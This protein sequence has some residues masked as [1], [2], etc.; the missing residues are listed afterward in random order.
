MMFVY[1]KKGL[2][3]LNN[4]N[5][6]IESLDSPTVELLDSNN[7]DSLDFTPPLIP[8]QN[9]KKYEPEKQKKK[10]VIGIIFTV[11]GFIL[12]AAFMAGAIYYL[13]VFP[14]NGN[15][16]LE[17][18]IDKSF[19]YI[20]YINDYS[21][22]Y[23]DSNY[24]NNSVSYV[25]SINYKSNNLSHDYIINYEYDL[26]YEN[27]NI[28]FGGALFT[29][30]TETNSFI[31]NYDNN[32]NYIFDKN[33]GPNPILLSNKEFII[34]QN[35]KKSALNDFYNNL[36]NQKNYIINNFNLTDFTNYA[37][38]L[39]TPS[40]IVGKENLFKTSAKSAISFEDY[41]YLLSKFKEYL[42]E[43]FSENEFDVTL[44]I[45]KKEDKYVFYKKITYLLQN[46]VFDNQLDSILEKVQND[47]KM[48]DILYNIGNKYNNYPEGYNL[49]N[50]TEYIKSLRK[51]IIKSYDGNIGIE[52]YVDAFKGNLISFKLSHEGNNI[53]AY[54]NNTFEVNIMLNNKKINAVYKKKNLSINVDDEEI[55]NMNIKAFNKDKID[56]DYS[57]IKNEENNS[58]LI[59]NSNIT[60]NVKNKNIEYTFIIDKKDNNIYDYKLDVNNGSEILNLSGS[61]KR[62]FNEKFVL[63]DKNNVVYYDNISSELKDRLNNNL[64]NIFDKL[65]FESKIK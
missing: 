15:L 13:A 45:Q 37:D 64:N 62:T 29:D 27:K 44:S 23:I 53:I 48:M 43:S 35:P 11:L 25:G 46:T 7:I 5:N 12:V 16:V 63:Y 49:D 50:V 2:I 32:S 10:S 42:N 9:I 26:D 4:E 40:T 65:C 34:N 31:Y 19:N 33:V 22:N 8:E 59:N 20:S 24:I 17:N 52:I 38:M 56:I 51:D 61:V 6:S 21:K 39:L 14:K 1:N 28:L 41:Y 18:L 55:I 36:N 60:M 54:H 57:L 58:I 30:N 47:E 3:T